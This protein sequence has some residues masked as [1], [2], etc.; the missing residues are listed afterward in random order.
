M[1]EE[2]KQPEIS[3]L[4][5]HLLLEQSQPRAR[6]LW[7][8]YAVGFFFLVVISSALAQQSL[9]NG[10]QIVQMISS[11]TMLGLMVAM[12]F[13]TWRASRSMQGE[14][15]QLGAIEEL[16][17][18]RRWEEA[19]LLVQALLS[20]PTRIP[21]ARTQ[22]LIFLGLILDRYHRFA[23][24]VSV[25]EHLLENRLVAGEAAYGMKL[26]RA[27]SLLREDRLVDA[28]R[29]MGELRR[30]DRADESAG[31]TL[32]EIYRDVKTGHPH[33]AIEEFEKKQGL[34]RKQLGY[35]MADGYA[36]AAKAFDLAGESEKARVVF[37][38]ATL[39]ASIVELKRRYPEIA[40]MEEKY[41]VAAMPAE[42]M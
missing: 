4:D 10:G 26:G 6:G 1:A 25:Y 16:I 33:E 36:L 39:L 24:A 14:R 2:Q 17:R 23:E 15:M 13:I 27:M 31:L 8:W 35:R 3:F 22:A 19:A 30:L 34:L 12:G 32:L 28:D 37:E 9:P 42:V 7:F 18:L 41:V 38:K 11:L 29:A 20:R 21:D 40:G 5:V